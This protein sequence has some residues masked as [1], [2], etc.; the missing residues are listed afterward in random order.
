MNFN[1]LQ[2][3]W[4][5]TI[6]EGNLDT[7]KAFRLGSKGVTITWLLFCIVE[8]DNHLAVKTCSQTDFS[9]ELYC[10]EQKSYWRSADS[11]H[12]QKPACLSRNL[13]KEQ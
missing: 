9:R 10:N 12:L 1:T 8:E 4:P 11:R 7:G 13:L 3:W 6:R 5:Q 2:N